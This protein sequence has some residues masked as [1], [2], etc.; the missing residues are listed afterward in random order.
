VSTQF[1][2]TPVPNVTYSAC[3]MS[4][5]EEMIM[6]GVAPYPVERTMIV[7]G[8]LKACLTSKVQGNKLLPTPQLDVRYK[9][10]KTSQ[11]ART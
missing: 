6:T 7:S 3:L 11:Y 4:K 1:F 9:A 2:L 10:P 8:I 5:I